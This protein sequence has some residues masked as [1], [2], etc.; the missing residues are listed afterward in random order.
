MRNSTAS[1][2]QQE[3]ARHAVYHTTLTRVPR[4]SNGVVVLSAHTLLAMRV[5]EEAAATAAAANWFL[6]IFYLPF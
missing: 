4:G 6:V 1:R 3:R 2:R 5:G